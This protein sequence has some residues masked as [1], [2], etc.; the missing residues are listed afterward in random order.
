M[1][2]YKIVVYIARYGDYQRKSVVVSAVSAGEAVKKALDDDY[3]NC[4][5]IAIHAE[6][7]Y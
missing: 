5:I 2:E 7:V 3:R 1:T 4:D 6:K